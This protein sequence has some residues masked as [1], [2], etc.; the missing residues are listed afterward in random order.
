MPPSQSKLRFLELEA[1][2]AIAMKNGLQLSETF[3]NWRREPFAEDSPE[4]IIR[5]TKSA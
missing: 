1:I 2:E 5:L 3:G 4:I